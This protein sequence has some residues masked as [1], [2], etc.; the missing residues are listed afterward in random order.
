[1]ETRARGEVCDFTLREYTPDGWMQ[2][3][4]TLAQVLWAGGI[5]SDLYTYLDKA[6]S[7]CVVRLT[8]TELSLFSEKLPGR[9]LVRLREADETARKEPD[10]SLPFGPNRE[11]YEG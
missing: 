3:G 1:M 7:V 11:V 9:Y 8:P 4:L 10:R 6:E 5:D 2:D